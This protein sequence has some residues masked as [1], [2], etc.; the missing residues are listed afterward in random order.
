MANMNGN[1]KCQIEMSNLRIS[2][3]I[4]EIHRFP[5]H[6]SK[7]NKLCRVHVCVCLC[8]YMSYGNVKSKCQIEMSNRNVKYLNHCGDR[9]KQS[10]CCRGV[11]LFLSFLIVFFFVL[12]VYVVSCSQ[13]LDIYQRVLCLKT[14]GQQVVPESEEMSAGA[15]EVSRT[16]SLISSG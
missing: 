8:G 14:R 7:G 6:N 3:H 10:N 1:Y 12:F 11:P 4:L 16:R 9:S 5:S 2:K 15:A 13:V